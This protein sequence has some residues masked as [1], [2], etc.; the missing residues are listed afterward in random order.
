MN[1]ARNKVVL[2]VVC[3]LSGC[4]FFGK[5]EPL[6]PTF[7]SPEQR[8]RQAQSVGGSEQLALRIG[9]VTSSAHLRERIAYH[10]SPRALSFYEQR[11]WTERPEAYLRRAVSSALF[12]QA[13]LAHVVSG[14]APTL[15]LEL[16][17]FAEVREPAHGGRVR[18][19]AMLSDGRTAWFERTFEAE[20]RAQGD[21][22][23]FTPVVDALAAALEQCVRE[24]SQTT[25]SALQARAA[26]AAPAA[27]APL[28]PPPLPSP[29][30]P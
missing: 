28:A 13:G 5:A 16:L 8:E 11:R 24:L 1:Q 14:P 25:I 15:E 12:E 10:S 26:T 2:L 3:A 20:Q 17:E 9:R 23:D 7:Y 19:R 27:P 21:G 4:A 6:S 29:P 22:D 30:P 18:L